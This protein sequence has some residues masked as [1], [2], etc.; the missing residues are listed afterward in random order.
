MRRSC[1]ELGLPEFTE[2]DRRLV[3]NEFCQGLVSYKEIK[4]REVWPFLKVWLSTEQRSLINTYAPQK[5]KLSNGREV[6][7]IYGDDTPKIS[8]VLQQLYDVSS[9]PTICNGK[10]PVLVE[11]LGPNHRP[12]QRTED[13]EGF[14]ESSYPEIRKQLKGR[15]PKHEWR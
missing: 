4:E 13:L 7:V 2:E 3:I 8:I 15:Y 1:P 10:V 11:I 5:I 14:W 9:V 12:V 6:K